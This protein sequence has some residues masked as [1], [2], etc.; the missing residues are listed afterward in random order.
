MNEPG[1]AVVLQKVLTFLRNGDA[2]GADILLTSFLARSPEDADGQ[3]LAGLIKR[4][5]GDVTAAIEHFQAAV[6]SDPQSHVYQ[7]NLSA[8]LLANDQP[9]DALSVLEEACAHH[10]TVPELHVNL[11]DAFV[12][13]SREADAETALRQALK[14]RPDYTEAAVN[15][16][17]LLQAQGNFAEA[18]ELVRPLLAD[19]TDDPAA[20][21]FLGMA[22]LKADSLD[23]AVRHLARAAALEPDRIDILVNLGV[24][25]KRAG[26]LE[27][28]EQTYRDVLKQGHEDAGILNNLGNVLASRAKFEDAE[29]IFLRALDY[30]STDAD[31]RKNLA[32]LLQDLER[33]DEALELL[34][35]GLSYQPNHP[36]LLMAKGN[37]L[38]MMNQF[39]EAA[40]VL[41]RAIAEAPDVAEAHN[42]YGL[43][44]SILDDLD[45]AESS[46]KKAVSLKPDE[47]VLHNNLGAL[48]IRA[49]K[50]EEALEALNAAMKLN[51][52]YVDPMRNY[53]MVQYLTGN[54][55]EAR[56]A[57]RRVLDL[58][59][60]DLPA[61]HGLAIAL[62]EDQDLA[63]AEEKAQQVLRIN[64]DYN[65]TRNLLGVLR[66]DQR[67]YEEGLTEMKLAAQHDTVSAPAFLS[68]YLFSSMYD[69]ARST[70]S[71]FEDH[72]AWGAR[73]A[74]AD[75]NTDRPHD[76][77]R[78]PARK[79]RIGYVSPDFRAH[80]VAYFFEPIMQF[81]DRDS[82]EVYCYS[83]T[84]RTDAITDGLRAAAD[85]WIETTGLTDEHMIGRLRDDK[86]DILINLGG[87]HRAQS[88]CARSPAK[89]L[90][91]RSSTWGIP[92]PAVCRRW[93][94]ACPMTVLI[95]PRLRM[96]L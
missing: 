1:S 2:A 93:A 40:D 47:P 75:L 76:H 34:D 17:S 74:S 77:Q 19:A 39:K 87:A 63:E 95:P 24:A 22:E 52:D 9:Q 73:F 5:L 43:V 54:V 55:E 33:N 48:L 23:L 29:E 72:K 45:G 41:E 42:N 85:G 3:N 10:P 6:R 27:S 78:D 21:R 44:Q 28:A 25:Q 46:F 56:T 53:A 38:R 88:V 59:P 90:L 82:F 80:S 92:T 15:L 7:V 16:C 36:G 18:V 94:I 58:A 14:L 66:V 13:V 57:Y 8:A 50:L 20:M 91:F 61:L 49:F 60:E 51:P 64:P 12:R 83:N 84:T 62:W 4:Q 79:L 65:L 35:Q 26:Q 89:P 70:Q 96:T 68:N 31:V 81:H 86:V 32:L 71:V 67:R 11:A 30:D 37:T 69:P